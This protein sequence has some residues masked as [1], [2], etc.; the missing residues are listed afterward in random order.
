M[1]RHVKPTEELSG[2]NEER[3]YL[4]EDRLF[5]NATVRNPNVETRCISFDLGT[6]TYDVR[7]NLGLKILNLL[8]KIIWHQ[9]PNLW[10]R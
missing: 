3:L 10:E 1:Q 4:L 8:L 6:E 2:K 9:H 5:S 7:E